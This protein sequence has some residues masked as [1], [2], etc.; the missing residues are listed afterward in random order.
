MQISIPADIYPYIKMFCCDALVPTEDLPQS[1]RKKFAIF[2][3]DQFKDWKKWKGKS[4]IDPGKFTLFEKI[5]GR[6]FAFLSDKGLKNLLFTRSGIKLKNTELWEEVPIGCE[7]L[8]NM[9]V[10]YYKAKGYY[11]LFS[12]D[13]HL[14]LWQ[15]LLMLWDIKRCYYFYGYEETEHPS[16]VGY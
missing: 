1:L 14:N 8:F 7:S 16:T 3:Y 15:H 2:N 6:Q 4:N 11:L 12:S 10:E 9:Y 13:E 5:H